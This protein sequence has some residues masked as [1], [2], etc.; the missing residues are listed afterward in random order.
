MSKVYTGSLG[1][2]DGFPGIVTVQDDDAVDPAAAKRLD[3]RLD[4]ANHS[5]TGFA[6]GYAGS[7]PAQ[8]AL[9]ICADATRDDEL[10]LAVHQEFKFRAIVV[11]S[12][13][14]AWT[15][16]E[17]G[18]MGVINQIQRERREAAEAAE[19]AASEPPEAPADQA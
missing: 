9:A 11:L 8:L 10:A 7:G 14:A 2:H 17:V 5:P 12:Q 1:L 18:V 19:A 16:T 15:L 13:R 4:L 3:P 6:W